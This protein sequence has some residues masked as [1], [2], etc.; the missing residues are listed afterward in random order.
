[1]PEILVTAIVHKFQV[2]G[3]GNQRVSDLE[4]GYVNLVRAQLIIETEIVALVTNFVQSARHRQHFGFY[5]FK[6]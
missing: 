3:V 5:G 1:M 2:F 4:I 6:R